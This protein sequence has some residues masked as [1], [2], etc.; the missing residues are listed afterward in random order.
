MMIK[1]FLLLLLTLSGFV[2][3][4]QL[5]LYSSHYINSLLY[6]P[7]NAGETTDLR[8]FLHHRTQWKE[9]EG[10]PVVNGFTADAGLKNKKVGLGLTLFQQKQGLSETIKVK[11]L[12]SYR[13]IITETSHLSF[14][15]GAGIKSNKV[16]FTKAVAFDTEDPFL[17][18]QMSRATSPDIDA[19]VSYRTRF[20]TFGLNAE[21][22]QRGF[23]SD[24]KLQKD[25]SQYTLHGSSILALNAD[26]DISLVPLLLLKAVPGAPLHY[27]FNTTLNWRNILWI[28]GGYKSNYAANINAAVQIKRIKL[29]Y[30]Y[31]IPVNSL[32]AQA[33]LTHEIT[34]G[35]SF[36]LFPEPEPE[37]DKPL[38]N[39]NEEELARLKLELAEKEAQLVKHEKRIY[40]L[41]DS[42]YIR[43]NEQ[44]T[45]NEQEEAE[46]QRKIKEQVNEIKIELENYKREKNVELSN[47]RKRIE[48]LNEILKKE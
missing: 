36:S 32:K 1:R 35:Y 48:E 42:V 44:V 5:P 24:K 29:G 37:E 10:A 4:Q 43:A 21:Q 18:S 13:V 8:L 28:G 25:Q 31:E 22:L 19:G 2:N 23:I 17:S 30:S 26:K 14:G 40:E 15:I 12:Y 45:K 6:N 11:A 7:S 47:I 34:L 9:F 33:G 41:I 27:D 38:V 16:N 3:A 39:T 20:F 46:K